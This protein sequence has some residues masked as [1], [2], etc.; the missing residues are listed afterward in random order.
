MLVLQ[1]IEATAS[2]DE[3]GSLNVGPGELYEATS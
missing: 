1:N 3:N 2:Q